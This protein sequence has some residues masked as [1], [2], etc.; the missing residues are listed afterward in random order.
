MGVMESEIKNQEGNQQYL[1][2]LHGNVQGQNTI[3]DLP[4]RHI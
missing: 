2:L 4:R 1:N 3:S